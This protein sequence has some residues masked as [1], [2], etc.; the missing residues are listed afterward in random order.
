MKNFNPK[1]QEVI[2]DLDN[3]LV[4]IAAAGTGKTDT[5]AGRVVKIIESK[6]A[7][8][9][10]IL[11]ITFTN[12]A[13]KEMKERIEKAVGAE[14]KDVTIKT[15]HSWC[16]DVIKKEAKKQTDLYTDFFVQD[17]EDCKEIINEVKSLLPAFMEPTFKVEKLLQ[18]INLVKEETALIEIASPGPHHIKNVINHIFKTK[19]DKID[20]VCK[21]KSSSK[22][23]IKMKQVLKENGDTL[24]HTYNMILRDNRGVDFADLILTTLEILESPDVVESMKNTYKYINVDEVQDTSIVEYFIIQKIFGD[25][26]IL[27]CGDTFQTIYHW[28]GSDPSE[29]LTRF[30][31]EYAPRDIVFNTNYRATQNLVNVSVQY[32]NSAFPQLVEELYHDKLEVASPVKGQKV[33][34]KETS[35][36]EA[37][38]Q[39][40]Y[41]EIKNNGL[42]DKTCILTRDNYYNIQLSKVMEGLQASGDGFE[43]ILVDQFK[44]FRRQEV[45]DVIAFMKLIANPYD[46]ISLKRILKR[47][48]TGI[49]KKT[50]ELIESPG[51]RKLGI[52]LTDFIDPNTRKLGEPFQMLI[53]EWQNNNIV[54]FDVESTGVDPTQDQIIQIAAMRIDCHGNETE[55]FVRFLKND[56]SVARSEH[57]HGFSDSFLKANGEDRK[58]VFKEFLA[59]SKDRVIVG[60]N[61]SFDIN[62]LESELRKTGLQDPDF[63]T[64]YDTLDIYRRFYPNLNNHKLDNL[65]ELFETNHRPTHDAMDD[66]LATSE[67]LVHALKEKIIP[68]SFQRMNKV[69]GHLAAFSDISG[70][71]DDF[72]LQVAS[73]RPFDIITTIVL[74]FKMKQL[75]SEEKIN[76]LRKFYTLIEEIDNPNKNHKDALL[77]VLKV[78]GLSNGDI[79]LLMLENRKKV[80]IP[81]ITVHQAKGLEFNT[82]FLAGVQESRFPSFRAVESDDLEE[83]K[84]TFYVAITRAKK[85]LYITCNSQGWYGSVNE[86]SRFLDFIPEEYVEIS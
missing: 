85:Q 7:K 45:K 66:I 71:L 58:Q 68:T 78:T 74:N 11:C 39:Y 51:Y 50:L 3:N 21:A 30:R 41:N 37:E 25:N 60:H 49:G 82:V 69:S 34:V 48:P 77:E 5:L 54:V 14:G 28:R 53:D 27:L 67:L 73:K 81:I 19:S 72:F 35:S 43:F 17:E 15:F 61:V 6:K 44:F 32:L 86:K 1:Q 52:K 65:S 31:A 84:R 12:K 18:F 9:K 13:S 4:V 70:Q 64:F 79:E 56:K 8:G 16:F 29:I 33:I 83:E 75:Y 26:K 76:N 47:F 63:K 23:N 62:I 2:D 38:A 59:F 40:I 46:A 42:F 36:V 57:V 55:R 80:R 10:E 22:V 24:V 20:E